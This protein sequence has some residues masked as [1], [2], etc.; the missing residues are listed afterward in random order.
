MPGLFLWSQ[1]G[2]PPCRLPEKSGTHFSELAYLPVLPERVPKPAE[3][4]PSSP[5]G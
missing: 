1:G 4:Y 3:S 2:S 5:S